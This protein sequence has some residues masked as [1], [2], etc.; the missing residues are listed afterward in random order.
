M[1]RDARHYEQHTWIL[2]EEVLDKWYVSSLV[3][4]IPLEVHF[5]VL[6]SICLAY[7]L[8]SSFNVIAGHMMFSGHY[9]CNR[10]GG[11]AIAHDSLS[12]WWQQM[13]FYHMNTLVLLYTY[14]YDFIYV[15]RCKILLNV[16]RFFRINLMLDSIVTYTTHTLLINT[17]H[18]QKI[19]ITLHG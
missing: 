14:H 9:C 7:M 16:A 11:L 12:W 17:I 19:N 8:A 2:N 1:V 3:G 13:L 10:D 15:F 5:L 18:I 4:V 6:L